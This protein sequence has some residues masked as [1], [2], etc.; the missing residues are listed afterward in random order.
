MDWDERGQSLI[1]NAVMFAA[2][3]L[4]G[5]LAKPLNQRVRGEVL[6]K[7]AGPR[8][9]AIEGK[10]AALGPEVEAL[11][12]NPKG[13][14]A[15]A[16]LCKKIET[17]WNE[18]LRQLGEAAKTEKENPAK[19]AEEFKATVAAYQA[20][21]AKLDLQLSQMGLEVQ[22]SPKMDGNLFRAIRP[23]YVAYRPEGLEIL[24][25]FYVKDGGTLTE[26]KDGQLAGKSKAGDEIGAGVW[27]GGWLDYVSR[28]FKMADPL[29]P[30]EQ[31]TA[32]DLFDRA[33]KKQAE[34]SPRDSPASVLVHHVAEQIPAANQ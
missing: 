6:L 19:A 17:L 9:A 13:P 33:L 25:D 21:I 27:S 22:L 18:E 32:F 3:S 8:L 16:E 15:A 12:T 5:F 23:G 34:G 24:K 31:I 1:Q 10:L 4:G 20:E 2:L 29:K 28:T 30:A 14:D 26:L 7:V 11:K